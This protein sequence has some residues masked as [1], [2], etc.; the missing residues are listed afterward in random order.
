LLNLASVGMEAI[1]SE[2]K[3]SLSELCSSGLLLDHGNPEIRLC[4]SH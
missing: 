3:T 1:Q 4:A 2:Q